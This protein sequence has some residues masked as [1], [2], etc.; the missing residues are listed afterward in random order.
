MNEK[1]LIRIAK[2][3]ADSGVASRREA[4]RLI[5]SGAVS[6]NGKI[7]NTPVFF[8]DGSE[9]IKINNL[10]LHTSH[11]TLLYA[12][13]KPVDV[14]T[15]ASDPN[16]RATIYDRLPEK[17][18]NLKYIGRLDYKT[19]GLLLLT[20]DGELARQLTLP[21]SEIARTYIAKLYPKKMDEIK[22]PKI[23]NLLRKFLSPVFS[24][25]SLFDLV[26]GGI[27]IDKIKYAPID[28]EIM[29]RYPL[30]VQLTLREGKKNEI[31]IIMDYIGLPVKKLHRISYGNIKLGKLP[32]GTIQELSQKDID[33]VMKSL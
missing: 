21:S 8:V 10:T 25:E 11:P 13:H 12:F 16:G 2:F 26:R 22:N 18:R 15:T 33:A 4:E 6:V 7:I 3:I 5:E 31:R 14:M 23:A 24:D 27:T 20:N 32:V 28:V 17:Y 19:S 1:T 29:A 9:N 30:T